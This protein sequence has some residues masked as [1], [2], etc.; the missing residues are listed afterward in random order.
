MRDRRAVEAHRLAVGLH[1]EL[2]EVG[3]EAAPAP[4]RTA[5]PPWSRSRARC[6]SRRRSGRAAPARWRPSGAVRKCSSMA[7]N[8]ARNSREVVA[9]RWRSSATGRSPSRPSSGRRPSPRSRTCW[10]CRCRTPPPSSAF[11]LTATK[12]SGDGVLA[13][14]VDEPRPGR[15]GVGQ[16]LDRGERLRRHDEQRRAPGRARR[17]PPAMS[18][19]STLET[20]RHAMSRV[21]EGVEGAVGHRRA[22]VGAADAD[23]DHG[24]DPLAG[25]ARPRRRRAP[26]GERAHPRRA[27]RARRARRRAPSTLDRPASSRPARAARRAARRGA[28]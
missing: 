12:C 1:V 4:G 11:V 28:R 25:R 21:A 17:A 19:P 24:A 6:R 8:P 16:R 22:E 23:V 13:E 2:L 26:V 27:P 9:A 5:A 10:R 15:A 7:W 20:K 18:A 3:R 14:R